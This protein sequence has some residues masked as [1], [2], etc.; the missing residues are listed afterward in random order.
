LVA[1]GSTPNPLL[2][3]THT[4]K[5]VG[6]NKRSAVLVASGLV[7]AMVSAAFGIMM[8]FTGPSSAGAEGVRVRAE[9]KPV[10]KTVTD[11]RTIHLAAPGGASGSSTVVLTR[12]PGPSTGS[13]D[14]GDQATQGSSDDDSSDPTTEPSDEP[15]EDGGET[16]SPE[17][18]ESHSE[19]P[20]PEPG[21]D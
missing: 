3:D 11:K 13:S 7:L 5:G 20:A 12:T 6:M 1:H 10:V 9:R 15:G 2:V 21:D 19:S 17:P 14:D 4:E 16:E 8:G 18:S